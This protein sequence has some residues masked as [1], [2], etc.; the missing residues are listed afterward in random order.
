MTAPTLPPAAAP[1]APVAPDA[2]PRRVGAGA[3]DARALLSAL[4]EAARKLDP[5]H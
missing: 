3:F 1:S 2:G 5:R 4:P